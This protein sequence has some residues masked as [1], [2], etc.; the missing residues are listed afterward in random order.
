MGTLARRAAMA[1]T[2]ALL[3]AIG[4]VAP[5]A[6]APAV[7]FSAKIVPVAGF[8][9]TG[10]VAREGGALKLEYTID[11][12][13]YRGDPPPLTAIR[14]TFP[15]GLKI[16]QSWPSCP[17]T[18]PEAQQPQAC[19]LGSR[20]GPPGELRAVVE[21]A[22]TET[23][24][25]LLPV[26]VPGGLAFAPEGP[27]EGFDLSGSFAPGSTDRNETPV[28]TLNLPS[29][30]V[31]SGAPAF[32]VRRLVV[33]I[34]SA[35]LVA[36]KA[37]YYLRVPAGCENGM[38]P[39]SLLTFAREGDPNMPLTVDAVATMPC[40]RQPMVSRAPVAP[41]VPPAPP[42]CRSAR[43]FMIHI[44]PPKG[45]SYR[46]VSVTVDGRNVNVRRRGGQITAIV[47]LRGLPRGTYAVKVIATTGGG[48]RIVRTRLYRTCAA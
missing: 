10:D 11:G 29:A 18:L 22:G 45:V 12:T 24:V 26:A 47:D 14:L 25:A 36:H 38:H 6:A 9:H 43:R 23:T 1:A 15:E 32:S 7:A 34:G 37:S 33:E 48:R 21:P 42:S 4:S 40:P 27:P 19:P 41:V 44:D 46:R 13:E 3:G 5:A 31:G 20:A 2:G 8:L 39:D 17:A 35:F 16:A 30:S 28:L